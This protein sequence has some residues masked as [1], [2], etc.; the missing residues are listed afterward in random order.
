MTRK[1]LPTVLAVLI[2]AEVVA[3]ENEVSIEKPLAVVMGPVMPSTIRFSVV[4]QPKATLAYGAI[5]YRIIGEDVWST[6]KFP[7]SRAVN[8][9]DSVDISGLEDG[10]KYE[11]R[12][13]IFYVDDESNV[14]G[15]NLS[16]LDPLNRNHA[17][18]CYYEIIP[19]Y[20]N[21]VGQ[22]SFALI[23]GS[24]QYDGPLLE[25][26]RKSPL[27]LV[28]AYTSQSLL[29][30]LALASKLRRLPGYG[31]IFN[32]S[33]VDS[34]LT[35]VSLAETEGKFIRTDDGETFRTVIE[36]A[37]ANNLKMRGLIDMG[38]TYYRDWL[39]KYAGAETAEAVYHLLVDALTTSGRHELQGMMPTIVQV[40]D[41][42]W[43]DN[44]NRDD[45]N[46]DYTDFTDICWRLADL[47][48]RQ[49]PTY[50]P[51]TKNIGYRWFETQFYGLPAFVCDFRSEAR[52]GVEKIS[53]A[54]FAG[55]SAFIKKWG[56]Y[57]KIIVS[58]IPIGPDKIGEP[59]ADKW[60]DDGY[61]KTRTDILTFLK[62]KKVK[63]T[64]W[65][66][67]DIHAGMLNEVVWSTNT[68][69]EG[70]LRGFFREEEFPKLI[71]DMKHVIL[72]QAVASPFNWPIQFENF[73]LDTR[74]PLAITKTGYFG[75]VN[76]S[77]LVKRNHAGLFRLSADGKQVVIQIL[78]N[79]PDHS[80]GTIVLE[81]TY[82]LCPY[83]ARR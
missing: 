66:G 26:L 76:Q 29:R 65:L 78:G 44:F 37:A 8:T 39:N 7:I 43:R 56:N 5:Q 6:Q 73:D 23:F 10:Q 57:P 42:A 50:N 21:L 79:D 80:S 40:D 60:G 75:V 20:R 22:D 72:A 77:T 51:L 33:C 70:K 16:W 55:L 82:N 34:L 13:G 74:A 24:C 81:R 14:D 30:K 48:Q 61:L 9:A 4:A 31:K 19:S 35:I 15:V 45:L 12:I 83:D 2:F 64:F 41:H 28:D 54:Q 52:A 49:H 17:L 11:C 36:F 38:D 59:D 68:T 1:F 47:L 3:L 18:D 25:Y 69:G 58:Q 62:E 67:G 32:G 53:A 71:I 63:N 27:R 46:R